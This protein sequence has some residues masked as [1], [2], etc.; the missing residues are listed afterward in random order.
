VTSQVLV[1]SRYN[2]FTESA[3]AG[4]FL[5]FNA[6]TGA[7]LELDAEEFALVSAFEGQ[8]GAPLPS[9]TPLP[10]R[11]RLVSAGIVV[12]EQ[13]D[14]RGALLDLRRR[15]LASPDTLLLTLAPTIQ[16]NFRCSYCFEAHRQEVMTPAIESDVMRFIGEQSGAVRAINT[17]WFGGEPLL[18][19]ETLERIQR[20]T[21]ELGAARGIQIVRGLVTNGYFLTADVVR[22]LQA[23]GEWDLIQVTVDG[24]PE[25]HDKRRMLVGG[26]GTWER[27]IANCRTALDLGMRVSVR[28]NADRRNA[29]L[30]GPLLDRL[31]DERILPAA[32]ISLGFVVDTTSTCEHVAADVLS[33]EERA[34]IA[35]WFDA[36]KLRRHLR[37]SA[38]L[39]A[40]ICGPM[41]SVESKL[42]FVVAPSGLIF[43]C[44][45][46]IDR[47]E[48]EAIGHVSGRAMPNAAAEVA[49]WARY[50]PGARQGCSNC[51]ALPACMGGCPWE[52]ERLGRVD[53]GE[54]G[55]FR[56]YPKEIVK[57]AHVRTRFGRTDE[58]EL[59]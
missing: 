52:F 43:K 47:S 59:R 9:T 46:Q 51:G 14:E 1:A 38:A 2:T 54:C 41:C 49:R 34:R 3:A 27:I 5:A 45:N 21:N 39:P 40:P 53:R 6:F 18:R 4:T 19:L 37:P 10:L 11:E 26:G 55:S 50:D 35:I 8:P 44:W 58:Q 36:E 12:P 13:F 22:R 42:G 30:L 32:D 29:G 16:C 7:L 17:T 31:L 23:L 57:L 20:F 48:N 56:F 28:A 25:V 33:D 15:A 24:L